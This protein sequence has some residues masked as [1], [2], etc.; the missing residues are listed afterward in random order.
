MIS[1]P[2]PHAVR[3]TA[4]E[5]EAQGQL[6][7]SWWHEWVRAKQCHRFQ[8]SLEHLETSRIEM[9]QVFDLLKPRFEITVHQAEIKCYLESEAGFR[10]PC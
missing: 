10:K 5:I 6:S 1:R 8:A 3:Q 4:G 2:T 7:V 9:W